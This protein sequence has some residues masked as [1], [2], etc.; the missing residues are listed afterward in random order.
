MNLPRFIFEDAS[1]FNGL[2]NDLFPSLEV[3]KAKNQ[4]LFEAIEATLKEH[5]YQV[6]PDQVD[7]VMQVCLDVDDVV[8]VTCAVV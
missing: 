3:P 5:D 4:T 6:M 1:L 8:D 7:K 2:I